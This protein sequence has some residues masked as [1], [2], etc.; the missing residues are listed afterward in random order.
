MIRANLPEVFKR[1]AYLSEVPSDD[2]FAMIPLDETESDEGFT[3]A[4]M[5]KLPVRSID[6]EF[7]T[8]T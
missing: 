1:I 7:W 2:P 4:S 5:V 6:D 8:L 3:Q